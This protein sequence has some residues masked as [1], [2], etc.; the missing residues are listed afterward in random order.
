[1]AN[2]QLCEVYQ[3]ED[4][5][6]ALQARDNS[7]NPTNLTGKTVTWSVSFPPYDP[8]ISQA[9]IT[10]TGTVTS[11]STGGYT[12]TVTPGETACLTAGNYTHQAF[13]TD[14]TGAISYVTVGPFRVRRHIW[15]S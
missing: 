9:L 2:L 4:R 6:L 13:T 8:R 14:T 7:N 11:A 5:T 12:V 15:P 1:M 10:K 3:G